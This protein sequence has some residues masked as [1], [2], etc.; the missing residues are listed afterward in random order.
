MYR[1]YFQSIFGMY[2]YIFRTIHQIGLK[3]T[4]IS[5][6]ELSFPC[7]N[8]IIQTSHFRTPNQSPTWMM[9]LFY[10]HHKVCVITT[11]I[12]TKT[13]FYWANANENAFLHVISRGNLLNSHTLWQSRT[14]LAPA[15]KSGN[16]QVKTKQKLTFKF[17][18]LFT[19]KNVDFM[20]FKVFRTENIS[21]WIL[22]GQ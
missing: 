12:T 17:S 11:L 9:P 15:Q 18:T 5:N 8:Y 7:S 2:H 20:H 21:K 13:L 19:A 14:N 1:R 6:V 10:T 3:P 22:N 16:D 4:E